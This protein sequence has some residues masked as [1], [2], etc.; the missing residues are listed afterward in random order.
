[1]K[2]KINFGDFLVLAGVG[3]LSYGIWRI[4]PPAG[5][6]LFGLLILGTGASWQRRAQ[7]N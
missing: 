6:I 5:W 3:L 7:G 1:M 2:S 4:Y